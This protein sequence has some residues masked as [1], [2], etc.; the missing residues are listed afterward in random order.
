[1][2]T[3]QEATQIDRPVFI[4]GGS[5]TGST[6]L[7]TI[8]NKSPEIDL[9]DELH[10]YSLPWLRRDVATN[11][12]KQVGRLDSPH[13]LDKLMSLLYSGAAE[14]WFWQEAERLLD[15]DMMRRQLSSRPLTMQ[16]I[17]HA[18]LVV[19][20]E[21]RN[22]ARC[23]SKFPT[24]YL[25]TDKLLEWYPDCRLVHTTRNPKAVYASQANKYLS[26]EQSWF[27][28]G[29]MRFRQF[30]HINIQL[31]LTARLHKQLHELPN[32]QLVRYEDVVQDPVSEIQRVCD[33][34]EI[35]FL[36]QMLSP[37]RFGS[38]FDRPGVV[39]E[40]I[41]TSSLERWRTSI[42]PLTAKLMDLGHRRAIRILGYETG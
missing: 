23:G 42:H 13:A 10:F 15:R 18:I 12:R 39:G 4:I 35:D 27:S 7:R 9:A 1:M 17:F 28:R 20:A 22:K 25:F 21:M 36:P 41:E 29:Y 8:L 30:V 14:G 5:R 16:N 37:E 40:G 11:I 24:H 19:H 34:L 3:D 31:T 38:S 33:F 6:M 32:Y 26:E 2:T